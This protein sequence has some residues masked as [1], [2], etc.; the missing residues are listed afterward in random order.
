MRGVL[1]ACQS[2][3]YDSLHRGRWARGGQRGFVSIEQ[4]L[5]G[6]DEGRSWESIAPGLNFR[7]IALD[8]LSEA[9][10]AEKPGSVKKVGIAVED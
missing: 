3:R 1:G 4:A 8:G 9:E 6:R 5:A 2:Y 10:V 7:D